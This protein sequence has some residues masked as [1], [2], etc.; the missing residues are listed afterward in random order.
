MKQNN[1]LEEGNYETDVYIN[2][3]AKRI[4]GGVDIRNLAKRIWVLENPQRFDLGDTVYAWEKNEMFSGIITR[5]TPNFPK[6][7]TVNY[8]DE[9][10]SRRFYYVR[11]ANGVD[12]MWWNEDRLFSEKDI[13]SIR[14]KNERP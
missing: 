10:Y 11:P 7:V 9:N 6:Y 14:Q 2:D 8:L 3:I 4:L 12:G 1:Y 13:D 5:E